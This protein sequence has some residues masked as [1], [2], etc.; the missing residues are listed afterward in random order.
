M[1]NWLKSGKLSSG[2]SSDNVVS[3]KGGEGPRESEDLEATETKRKKMSGSQTMHRRKPKRREG[4]GKK[5][6][7]RVNTRQGKKEGNMMTII[8]VWASLGSAIQIARSLSAWCAVR[9]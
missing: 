1:L 2:T 8:W 7:M 6:I 9:F 4:D 5:E 3:H